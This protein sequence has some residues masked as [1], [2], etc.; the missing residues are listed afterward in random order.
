M[1]ISALHRIQL[2]NPLP[3]SVHRFTYHSGV[4]K[5]A[6]HG[7]GQKRSANTSRE[8]LDQECIQHFNQWLPTC[9]PA[10]VGSPYKTRVCFYCD[11]H[12]GNFYIC[13][14]PHREGITLASGGSGHGFKFAPVLGDIIADVVEK[15][16]NKYAH[17]FEWRDPKILVPHADSM[18]SSEFAVDHAKSKL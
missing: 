6:R 14:V 16:H 9:F 5:I 7:Y 10:L 17:A 8:V 12:D 15:K 3:L 1:H 11:T 2:D 18:R 13:P 4:V